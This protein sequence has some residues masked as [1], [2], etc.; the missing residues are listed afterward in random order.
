MEITLPPDVQRMIEEVLATGRYQNEEQVM[1]EALR[2]LTEQ[3]EDLQAVR[4]AVDEWKAGDPGMPLD[5]AFQAIRSRIAPEG[6][7]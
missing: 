7:T 6:N 5:R 1:R 4:E 3:E 2:V